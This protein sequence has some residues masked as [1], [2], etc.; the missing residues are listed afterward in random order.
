MTLSAPSLF[1]AA[2]RASMPPSTWAL[3]AEAADTPPL[4]LEDDAVLEVGGEQ[5]ETAARPAPARA[6]A[7]RENRRMAGIF[8]PGLARAHDPVTVGL[9]DRPDRPTTV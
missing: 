2:T 5:A 7:A 6:T 8:L 9:A 4:E 1:A 3:V